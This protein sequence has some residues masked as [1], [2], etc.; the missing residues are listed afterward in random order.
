MPPVNL[1]HK[2]WT[3]AVSPW[4][5][6]DRLG[7]WIQM[8]EFNKRSAW[9]T[10]FDFH[11]GLK[12]L[13]LSFWEE[14]QAHMTITV[15]AQSFLFFLTFWKRRVIMNCGI[16]HLC[17]R[18]FQNLS[19]EVRL[20]PSANDRSSDWKICKYKAKHILYSSIT[21]ILSVRFPFTIQ[22]RGLERLGC[23]MVKLFF[24]MFWSATSS[25]F[26]SQP[27]ICLA[28]A[29]QIQNLCHMTLP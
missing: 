3:F 19:C 9:V 22:S 17:N 24:Q 15:S 11:Y 8:K 4:S 14:M 6:Q 29:L 25:I 26:F 27:G 23:A 21:C 12:Y 1:L 2:T 28:L 5:E 16:L 10:V 13:A 18:S 20:L 7:P